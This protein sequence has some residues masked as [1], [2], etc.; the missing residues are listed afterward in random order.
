VIDGAFTVGNSPQ[1]IAETD[2]PAESAVAQAMPEFPAGEEAPIGANG[3]A[4]ASV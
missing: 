4:A 1:P 3:L 2:G